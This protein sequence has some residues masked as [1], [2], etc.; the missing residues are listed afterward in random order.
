[1]EV[2]SSVSIALLVL[3]ATA[4]LISSHLRTWRLVQ[5]NATQLQPSELD[6][7]RRQF[8]RRMQTSAMLGLVGIGVLAGRL[9]IVFRS[10]PLVVL[11]FWSGV[12]LL[13]VWLGLL[14]VADMI[15]TR[16]YFGRLRQ[17]YLV[18]EARLQVELRRLKRSGGNGQSDDESGT[19]GKGAG[20][21]EPEAEDEGLP[22]Q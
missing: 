12:V 16:Y 13:V 2:W 18:E 11:I 21:R 3:L 17:D 10:P 1:M 4:G 9:L 22:E 19:T 5:Q 14:A 8:R 7:R 6:Y 15:S 20:H